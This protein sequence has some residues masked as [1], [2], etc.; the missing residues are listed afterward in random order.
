MPT[1]L[2]N[3]SPAAGAIVLGDS[4]RSL[5]NVDGKRSLV[6]DGLFSISIGILQLV[7]RVILPRRCGR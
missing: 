4:T 5:G 2:S 3:L 6:V 1:K 7:V